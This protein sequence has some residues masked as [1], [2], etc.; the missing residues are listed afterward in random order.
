MK[1]FTI[2]LRVLAVAFI[3]TS[4]LHF[5]FGH[6]ADAMVGAPVS[7]EIAANPS[8]DSQNRFYG[9]TFSLLGVALIISSTDLR[10]YQPIISGTL[11]VLFMA[12]IA[13]VLAWVL[14]GAPSSI[15]IVI[16]IADLL[17]PPLFYFWLKRSLHDAA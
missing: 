8:L 12:G 5:F 13:R 6:Y 17:L 9:V 14:H 7:P 10:R 1:A 2:G 4:L 3:A 15:I 16:L 11:G